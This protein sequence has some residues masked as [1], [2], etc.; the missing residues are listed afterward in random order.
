VVG[1][2]LELVPLRGEGSRRHH[3]ARIVDQHVYRY[4]V[5]D[6]FGKGLD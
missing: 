4:P 5:D 2:E 6:T 1:G 3:D